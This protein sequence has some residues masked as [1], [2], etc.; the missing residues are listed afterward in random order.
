MEMDPVTVGSTGRPYL[1]IGDQGRVEV[2]DGHD[3]V[4]TR[5]SVFETGNPPNC[6][7]STTRLFRCS[8]AAL[9]TGGSRSER[10]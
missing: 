4:G 8:F 1:P 10:R 3:S 9:G 6:P 7:V 2:S 5:D